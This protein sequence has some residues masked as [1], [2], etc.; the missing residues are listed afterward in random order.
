MKK[1]NVRSKSSKDV[2]FKKAQLK[3]VEA[4]AKSFSNRNEKIGNKKKI[5]N[6]H[7]ELCREWRVLVDLKIEEKNYERMLI[8]GGSEFEPKSSTIKLYLVSLVVYLHEFKHVL[9]FFYPEYRALK[10]PE[11]DAFAWAL[12]VIKRGLPRYYEIVKRN[13]FFAR[14]LAEHYFYEVDEED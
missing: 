9:Q 3:T 5:F 2:F 6:L 11:E 7:S 13:S 4:I 12:A 14:F 8:T 10:D 1:R